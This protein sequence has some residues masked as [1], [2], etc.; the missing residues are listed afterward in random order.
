MSIPVTRPAPPDWKRAEGYEWAV[1]ADDGPL[2][3][4]PATTYEQRHKRCRHSPKAPCI[5][6]PVAALH[7]GAY[8]PRPTWWFYCAD[9]MYGRWIEDG[10][11]V[12]WRV[13]KSIGAGA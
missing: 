6:Q 12:S 13:R 2:S 9:H 5:K 11:V 8:G 1:V 3:W 7:R 4:R 10:H